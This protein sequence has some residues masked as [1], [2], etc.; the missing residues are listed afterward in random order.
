MPPPSTPC[1]LLATLLLGC[2]GDHRG[3]AG[4]A[5]GQDPGPP[6]PT[7]P[8]G[9]TRCYLDSDC[10][11]GLC[12]AGRCGARE[13]AGGVDASPD[14]RGADTGD[15]TPAVDAAEAGGD[16]AAPGDAS[17]RCRIHSDCP[18]RQVCIAGACGP[19]CREH[20]DCEPG[21]SC[22]DSLCQVPG[23]PCAG[24]AD[25]LDGEICDRGTCREEPD[26]IFAEDCA[27]GMDCVN[28]A[29]AAVG[30]GEGEGEGPG[31]GEGEGEGECGGY[32]GVCANKDDCCNELCLD[33]PPPQDGHGVCTDHCFNDDDC[34]GLD[35]CFS[36]G[37]HSVCVPNDVGS[38]C[39][40]PV[41]CSFGL[42]INDPN[43]RRAICSVACANRGRCGQMMGCGRVND[44]AGQALWAC[45]PVG[46]RCT[47]AAECTTA[48]CL[49]DFAGAATGYCTNDCRNDSDCALGSNC[50][51]I[52]DPEGIAVNVCV[53][54]ACP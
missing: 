39:R 18:E 41:E 50:C 46:G 12:N 54:G 10:D 13:D 32:G 37:P 40:D 24:P 15:A 4:V 19:E 22:R 11:A 3:G 21:A 34:L 44:Q 7:A 17:Q 5:G 49:P 6:G 27:R 35:V 26:C 52:P 14:A 8:D 20:R 9:G 43:T 25:C 31:E 33:I 16:A 30:E 53:R 51:G 47:R 36:V 45:V 29:C 28:G 2:S 42:C 38:D 1:L 23:A 48:R